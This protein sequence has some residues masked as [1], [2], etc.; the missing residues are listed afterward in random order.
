M[1]YIV[2]Y[3]NK[4]EYCTCYKEFDTLTEA[5]VFIEVELKER[6]TV[7]PE[8]LLYE[9]GDFTVIEG[10]MMIVE[11]VPGADGRVQLQYK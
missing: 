5:R 6:S 8:A 11:W 2:Q 3:D 7:R 4:Y 10:R 1:K 9:P